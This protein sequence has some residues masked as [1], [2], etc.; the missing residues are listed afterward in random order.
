MKKWDVLKTDEDVINKLSIN[1]NVSQEISRL[2]VLRGITNYE[3][4]ES[5]FRPCLTKAY[6]PFLMKGMDMAVKRLN[7]AKSEKQNILVYGDYDVDGT[8]SVSMMY[9]F[10]L[11]QEMNVKYYIPDRYDE[12]YGISRKGIDY[13]FANNINLIISLDCGIRA[14]DQIEYAKQYKIDFIIC[15]HHTPSKEIPDAYSVLNP[16]QFDCK[17]PNKDLSG[18]GVGF[19]LIT[20]YT[21]C[22]S[23]DIN[24]TYGYLGL[25][26]ISIVSDMVPITDENRIYAFHGLSKINNNPSAGIKSLISIAKRSD[27]VDSSD[28]LFGIAP[29]INAAGRISHAHEAVRVLIEGGYDKAK[30]YAKKLYLNNQ[31]RKD[32]EKRVFHE[33]SQ[34]IDKQKMSN[35]VCGKNWH[36]GVVGIV[37]SKLIEVHYRPTIVFAEDNGLF[38]GSARS[39]KGFDIYEAVSECSFL[40]ERFGG[41]KY[42]AGLSVRQENIK[43]FTEKFEEAVTNRIKSNQLTPVI[44]IDVD[45]KLDKISKKFLRIIKQFAPFGPGNPKPIFSSRNTTLEGA[46]YYIG[47][48]KS[49]VKFKLSHQPYMFDAIAFGFADFFLKNNKEQL[50]VCYTIEENNWNGKTSLQINIKDV[51]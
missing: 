15:D 14:I 20:A 27:K 9:M 30:V 51:F 44:S 18:C 17:Y 32:V 5:F 7:L 13:A 40:C 26:A 35:V 3:D 16:K 38:T 8:T 36:K 4:A 23:I 25:L 6:D 43:R 49:H 34:M 24:T 12:G 42:A 21:I 2:L 46:P 31:E 10:L 37:A 29:L 48:D 33:A 45:L 28:I 1:L 47:K 39:V 50:D 19:K 22:N 41:H 11:S